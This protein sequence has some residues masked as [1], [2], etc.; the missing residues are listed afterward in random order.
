MKRIILLLAG[1]IIS[2]CMVANAQNPNLG[3]AGAQF[4]KIPVGPR[5]AAMGGAYVSN[6]NDAS[7]LFWNPAGIVSVRENELLASYTGW[8]AGI[9]VSQAAYVHTFEDVGSFGISMNLLAMGDMDI[10]TEMQPEGTGQKFNAQDLMLGAS[11][12]R[13]LTEDFSVGITVKL[14]NQ[15]IWNESATGLAFDVGTQYRIGFRDLTI[16]MSMSNFGGDMKYDGRDLAVKY[17]SD[18]QNPNN[19]LA[20]AQLATEDY[21]LPLFFQ[22]GVSVSPYRSDDLTVLVATDVAHPN[23]NKERVN[24]GVEVSFLKQ[25]FLRGGYR[26]GYD[27][28]R[29]TVGGGVAVPFEGLNLTV[30]YA[31]AMYDLLPNISRF[32]IGMTF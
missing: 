29:G 8:W 7:A 3:T 2:I 14:V 19:R 31:Y 11:Y 22:V 32:S 5:G 30:D 1:F 27:T 18:T 15:R 9:T 26:F 16:G 23:D 10:T 24:V 13:R 12:A 6:A 4:L 25:F 17:D 21:P 20:P 28:E